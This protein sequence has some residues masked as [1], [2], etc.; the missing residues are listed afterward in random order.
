VSS[1]PGSGGP[2]RHLARWLRDAASG[3]RGRREGS[4]A[5]PIPEA[6]LELSRRGA[7]PLRRPGPDPGDQ[8]RVAAIVPSFR[9]GSGGHATLARVFE[10]L[11]AR[12]HLVTAWLEDCEGRHSSEPDALTRRSFSEFFGA[13][14]IELH[15]DFGAWQQTDI[16]LAT[17]W[18][19]VARAML[20]PE[21]AARA[22]LV[23]DHEPDFYGASAESLWAAQTYRWGLHCIA[24][25]GW[26][27]ELLHTRY[28]A[29]ATHFDLALDHRVY[30]SERGP[31]ERA[32]AAPGP[33][34]VLFYARAI[35]ARRAVPLGLLAL[36]ELKR[37][38][39]DV[40]VVLYGEDRPLEVP[41]AHR[42]AGLL[43]GDELAALYRGATVGMVLSLTNPSLVCLEMLACGLPCVEL[44]SESMLASFGGDGPLS[45]AEPDPLELCGTL[46]QLLDDAPRC[47]EMRRR[48]LE[49]TGQR[50]WEQA[51]EQVEEGL[52]RALSLAEVETARRAGRG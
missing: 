8:L 43:A 21:A 5:A 1:A 18:Q 32:D 22:Y 30:H 52:Y 2:V 51:A 28:G 29:S 41:F 25:S 48:G 20:L 42:N 38:R 40:E 31:A 24:A 45:L 47:T 9:R 6:I 19:T 36:A 33:D 17:G 14:Q 7:A 35:T 12:G 46:E 11:R 4:R 50:T 49:L 39:G 34:R 37:R 13:E 3:S 16:V 15:T 23:Q 10:A 27:A 26:L 44:A